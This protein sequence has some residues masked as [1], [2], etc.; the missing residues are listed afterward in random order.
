MRIGELLAR[1]LEREDADA[2]ARLLPL[3][4]VR[5][6]RRGPG[7]ATVRG[8]ATLTREVEDEAGLAHAGARGDDR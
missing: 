2:E 5:L 7:A 6:A 3:D 8:D 4:A 1:H